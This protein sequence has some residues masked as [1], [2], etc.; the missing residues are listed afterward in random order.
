MKHS[1]FIL[2]FLVFLTS[3]WSEKGSPWESTSDISQ[4]ISSQQVN[5]DSDNKLIV[6]PKLSGEDNQELNEL[7]KT[8]SFSKEFKDENIKNEINKI[9]SEISELK[10][11]KILKKH[12]LTLE[13][14]TSDSFLEDRLAL[15]DFTHP[16]KGT[17]EQAKN[18][19]IDI[20]FADY[21]SREADYTKFIIDD[22][23]LLEKYWTDSDLPSV[24]VEDAKSL[25]QEYVDKNI[26]YLD[27]YQKEKEALES[28]NFSEFLYISEYEVTQRIK[29]LESKKIQLSQQYDKNSLVEKIRNEYKNH[30]SK[31]TPEYNPQEVKTFFA[32]VY[33]KEIDSESYI[34]I[35]LSEAKSI[36][37][38]YEK[39][40]KVKL[41][42]VLK[43]W[44]KITSS[45]FYWKV[46][47]NNEDFFIDE[48]F[49]K[50]LKTSLSN[51]WEEF[52]I[53]IDQ[54]NQEYSNPFLSFLTGVDRSQSYYNS[55][56]TKL[57]QDINI[58]LA[59]ILFS[60]DINE[61]NEKVLNGD[62]SKDI[63][64]NWIL[65]NALLIILGKELISSDSDLTTND[66]KEFLHS[67]L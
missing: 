14:Y 49:Y 28:N 4:D 66:I 16:V 63:D 27:Y 21:N 56:N 31:V 8:S 48:E 3:C 36:V 47:Y 58:P 26:F 30:V 44:M 1:I 60:Y 43:S 37:A 11:W 5:S 61:N 65:S 15:S 33:N 24:R 54:N 6:N 9:D 39:T 22:N 19:D 38:Q 34:Y 40:D 67:V 32:N 41:T 20:F 62:T 18:I 13:D 53:Y 10:T 64:N 7:Y 12:P 2:L 29:E 51:N 50:S 59:S 23:S 45:N 46:N 52:I 42:K 35:S 57:L 55:I 17:T 25:L